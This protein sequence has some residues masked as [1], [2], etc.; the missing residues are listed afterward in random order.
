MW[1]ETLFCY[2]TTYRYMG[3]NNGRTSI[4]CLHTKY[5][6][7]ITRIFRVLQM[8]IFCFYYTNVIDNLLS[9]LFISFFFS[10][11]RFVI[12]GNID[13]STSCIS[14]NRTFK[15]KSMNVSTSR[16]EDFPGFSWVL[17]IC[18]NNLT[19]IISI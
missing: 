11:Q 18:L 14:V 6:I 16:Y 9:I 10:L 2:H 7:M 12:G 19:L 17:L 5:I 3:T 4:L 1:N 8:Y 13:S 15:L